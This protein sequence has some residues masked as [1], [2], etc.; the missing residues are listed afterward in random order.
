MENCYNNLKLYAHNYPNRFALFLLVVTNFVCNNIFLFNFK[1]YS[2]DWSSLVYASGIGTSIIK[3]LCDPQRPL[4]NVLFVLKQYFSEYVLFYHLLTLVTTTVFLILVYYLFIKIFHDFGEK[5]DFWPFIGALIFCV[6][7]NKDEIYPW[8]ILCDGFGYFAPV[9]TI[10]FYMYKEK[11]NYL[12]ISII[13]YFLSLM[14]YEVGV[15]VPVFLL[16]FDYLRGQNWKTTYYFIIPLFLYLVFR[17]TN[18][19]GFGTVNIDRGVGQYGLVTVIAILKSPVVISLVFAK[20][21]LY[22]FIGYTQMGLGLILILTVINLTLLYLLYQFMICS[23]IDDFSHKNIVYSAILLIITFMGPYIIRG[24][25]GVV[26]REYYLIDIGLSLLIVCM[27]MTL[28]NK[29]KVKILIICLVGFGIIINQGLFFN[30]VVSGDIQNNIN[31]Y[32][33]ENSEDLSKYEYV[34]FNTTSYK[35]NK[36]NNCETLYIIV[37]SFFRKHMGRSLG[38]I[39]KRTPYEIAYYNYFNAKCLDKW[40]LQAMIDGNTRSEITLI[41]GDYGTIPVNVTNYNI[42]YKNL[43]DGGIYTIPKEKVFEINYTSV[44][45]SL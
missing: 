21:I 5:N 1:Y 11:K 27:L 26:T 43:D 45:K 36:E 17:I 28:K 23:Q 31:K 38:I 3:S 41:Y 42:T 10:Y 44:E 8:A 30:W 12:F 35:E 14:T 6:L 22:S 40:A 13:M 24:G 2:D 25:L 33:E 16:G 15:M 19:F 7:F 34:Y 39:D 32:I 9:L 20:N 29:S 18:F 4:S 37:N